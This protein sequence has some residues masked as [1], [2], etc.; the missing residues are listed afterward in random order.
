M[1]LIGYTKEEDESDSNEYEYKCS[2]SLISELF[3]LSAA[4]CS[5]GGN[6][7]IPRIALFG[8]LKISDINHREIR[9]ISE[10]IENEENEYNFNNNLH[11]IILLKLKDSL[12]FNEYIIPICLPLVDQDI[13][14]QFVAAGWGQQNLTILNND[15]LL[16]VILTSSDENHCKNRLPNFNKSFQLCAGSFNDLKDT[17]RGDSGT[18]I[19]ENYI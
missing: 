7:E 1:V 8:V 9:E 5:D 11:D 2:G 15:H 10:V 18:K 19:T 12:I 3:V 14:T 17:C 6:H 16:K 4:H 13:G